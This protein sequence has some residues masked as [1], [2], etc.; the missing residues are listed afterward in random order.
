MQTV[1][2]HEIDAQI[3]TAVQAKMRAG[4]TTPA[5]IGKLWYNSRRFGLG[6][7]F[8]KGAQVGQIIKNE[9]KTRFEVIALA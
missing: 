9:D 6:F 1:Q 8:T 4:I 7:N 3:E 2:Q 5:A